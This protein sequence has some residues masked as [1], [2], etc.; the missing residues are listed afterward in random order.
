MTLDQLQSLVRSNVRQL[1]PYSSARDEFE[2][3]ASVYLDANENP[4]ENGYNRYPDPHQKA[5][6]KKVAEM[7]GIAP[8][9][10]FFGN[11]SDEAIDLLI[12]VFC[13]PGV[14]NVLIPQPTYG[15]YKVSADINEVAVKTTTLTSAFDLDAELVLKNVDSNT[16]IIFLCSPNNPSGNLLSALSIEKV[17]ATFNGVVVVDEAYIDF[18]ESPGWISRLDQ[19]TNLVILQ[20]FSKAWAL[21]SLRLGMAFAHPFIIE[22]MAKIK[23]PYNINGLTQK[24]ALEALKKGD[25]TRAWVTTLIGERSRL[26][27]RLGQL[28]VVQHIYPSDA[29]FIL[30]KT[31]NARAIY[32][33]L[34][35]RGIVVRD[36]SNVKLCDDCLR[37]TIGT[38]AEN[39][40]LVRELQTL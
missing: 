36:R 13:Q 32:E 14:H 4:F 37:V 2:G 11:G 34:L 3:T 17:A 18:A 27:E 5:L 7:K 28:R 25:Q 29:N 15:M 9:Q 31:T 38:P 24:L 21:A 10:V 35:Q 33:Q 20:T 8:N 22:M 12:R 26:I 19:F 16:R 39:D 30:V 40:R 23:P 1:S 6:K